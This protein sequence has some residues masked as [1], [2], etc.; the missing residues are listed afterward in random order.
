MFY[1]FKYENEQHLK[2]NKEKNI[3]SN[4]DAII[5]NRKVKI[6]IIEA[7][8]YIMKDSLNNIKG[9]D[10]EVLQEFIKEYN[11]DAEIIY[12]K[13][14]DQTKTYNGYIKDLADGKYDMLIGNISQT[15]ERSKIINFSQPL[16]VDI[17][18][19]FYKNVSRKTSIKYV[20]KMIKTILEV[21]VIILIIG[22]FISF[23][24]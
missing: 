23:I 22:F 18:S 4:K 11:I 19:I 21:L 3:V 13:S 2:E 20:Y 9:F 16:S 17:M 24:H 10:Y 7:E 1:E 12:L 14:S 15:H 8:P 6:G 5:S